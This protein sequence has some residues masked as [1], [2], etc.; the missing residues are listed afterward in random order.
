MQLFSSW[1]EWRHS[2]EHHYVVR[3]RKLKRG[4][5]LV[6]AQ[7]TSNLLFHLITH[8]IAPTSK[9]IEQEGGKLSQ[10]Q[11]TKWGRQRVGYSFPCLAMMSAMF[12]HESDPTFPHSELS[13]QEEMHLDKIKV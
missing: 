9:L 2:I 13:L 7:V 4:E 6:E 1:R 12:W 10:N 11:A 8:Q 5:K 3:S